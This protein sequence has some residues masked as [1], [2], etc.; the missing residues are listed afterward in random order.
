MLNGKESKFSE[1]PIFSHLQVLFINYV[2]LISLHL[3]CLTFFNSTRFIYLSLKTNVK[4]IAENVRMSALK[5]FRLIRECFKR[6]TT[7]FKT[8]SYSCD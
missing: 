8:A 2:R 5:C 3:S 7:I 1:N 6:R 4:E